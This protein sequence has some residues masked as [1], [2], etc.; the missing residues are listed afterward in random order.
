[1]R[2]GTLLVMGAACGL[3]LA[4]CGG[5][6]KEEGTI[7]VGAS[8]LT[9]THVFFQDLTAALESEAKEHGIR[10][11]IQYCEFDGSR[12]NDQLETFMLRGVDALLVA[13]Q[14][15]SGIAPVINEARAKGIP[16]FT[17]DI[18]A[19]G[20]DVVSHIA[21]DN[22]EGGRIIAQ[23]LADLLGGKGKVA[24]VDHPEVASVQ[25]RTAGFIEVMDGF[26]EIEIVQRVPGGGQRDKAFRA[27]QDLL[28]AR[29]DLDAIFGIN[30]DSALGALA[31]A[32]AA[33]IADRLAIVG[34]DG[35]PEAREAI[36]KGTAL[37]ADVVQHPEKIG[38][39]A[40]RIIAAHFRGEEVPRVV[41]VEVSV[42]DA[43]TL[44]A[45][46]GS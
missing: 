30:D 1:M 27:S 33:G 46:Q 7:T 45:E 28:Q 37:K 20:A 25:D 41:P 14:D 43:E 4:G 22:V 34:F 3:C 5:P 39:E 10:I 26:P 11:S 23:Y 29:P 32:E 13:P 12:Q 40:V 38:A 2:I 9:K 16:V 36:L 21:S 17:V 8:L 24:I 35:T 31:A 42:I 19:H 15:S 18:A 6:D 44:R